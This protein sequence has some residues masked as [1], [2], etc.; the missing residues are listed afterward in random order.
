MPNTYKI[1]KQVTLSSIT[2]FALSGCTQYHWVHPT[3]D[4]QHYNKDHYL[5]IIES[6]KTY[7]ARFYKIHRPGYSAMR[8]N[9][10]Y[11]YRNCTTTMY[12]A[13]KTE[14][15]DANLDNRDNLLKECMRAKGWRLE[16][17]KK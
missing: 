3:K 16:A 17:I 2:L 13:P 15:V 1:F 6:V 14:L 12:S 9:N 5:C 8:C 10:S 7:P 11:G 4:T